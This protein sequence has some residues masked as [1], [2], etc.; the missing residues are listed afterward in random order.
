MS[1]LCEVA[2]H[3]WFQYISFLVNSN[4]FAAC[5]NCRYVCKLAKSWHVYDN[6]LIFE[7]VR[8]LSDNIVCMYLFALLSVRICSY[9]SFK[10]WNMYIYIYVYIH[11]HTYIYTY[12]YMHTSIYLDCFKLTTYVQVSSW[13]CP[14]D[15]LQVCARATALQEPK[16]LQW[17]IVI[18]QV[19]YISY[20]YIYIYLCI[21]WLS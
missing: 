11:K 1:Y 15:L 8:H 21:K 19:L 10:Q 17:Y 6:C 5:K 18:Y 12:M 14:C 7:F 4:V 20:A 2:F 9:S 13:L 3:R 16:W